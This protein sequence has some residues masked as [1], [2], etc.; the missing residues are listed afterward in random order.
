MICFNVILLVAKLNPYVSLL[1]KARKF[2]FLSFY[3]YGCISIISIRTG[4][5]TSGFAQIGIRTCQRNEN[6][7]LLIDFL[8]E[9]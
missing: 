2:Q 4:D 6:G 1:I 9:A 8:K 5:A 7:H 3:L